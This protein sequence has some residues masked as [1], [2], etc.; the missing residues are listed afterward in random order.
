MKVGLTVDL[1]LMILIFA[2][3]SICGLDICNGLN[4]TK[5]E[6]HKCYKF[7]SLR[8]GFV[9]EKQ[10]HAL[11]EDLSGTEMLKNIN[12]D[13]IVQTDRKFWVCAYCVPTQIFDVCSE[14]I[15]R[16]YVHN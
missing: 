4:P 12:V 7:Y 13:E 16:H 5:R 9:N 15:V 14:Y 2:I 6:R 8:S 1:F 11:E 3:Q 10:H